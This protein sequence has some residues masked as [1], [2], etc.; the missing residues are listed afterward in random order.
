MAQYRFSWGLS[1]GTGTITVNGIEPQPFYEEG[2]SL[3]ILGTFDSGFTFQN[4]NINTGFLTSVFNPYTFNMPTRD[5]KVRV[6]LTGSF[7]PSDTDYELKYFSETEDQSLQLVRLEIYEY[8]Y[9]GS[10]IEKQTAGFQFR[11]GNFGTDEFEPL[12]R[13]YFNFGLV[14]TRDEYFE[15]LEGGYRKWRVRVL[16]ESVLFWE[17]YINNSTLTINEI[18]IK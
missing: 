8:G 10:A 4:Y 2:T 14:G 18:V 17:G 7:T 15:M 1:G 6:N 11:W 5:I 3:T 16:I 9:V 13:S 12:V